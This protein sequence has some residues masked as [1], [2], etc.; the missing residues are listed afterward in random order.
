MSEI[1]EER[2]GTNQEATSAM[3]DQAA[4]ALFGESELFGSLDLEEVRE[5]LRACDFRT[6]QP[7][8]VLFEQEDEADALY[9]VGQGQLEVRATSPL[10]EGIVLAE[11]GSG[12]VV[13]E[14][15]LIEGGPRSAT[16]EALTECQVFRLSRQAFDDLRRQRRPAA[17]K[18]ILALAATVGERRRQTDARIQEV[19]A[20][21]A[22]HID[23]FENQV[24]EMLGRLRK[25]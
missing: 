5:V 15:S 2:P 6:Y 25:A 20:D 8:T 16:V 10:G 12:T 4:E 19:F 14:M 18:I 11:L 1:E 3:T 22:Q 23:A 21:P 7:G 9:I 13:G 24:H 17:Y